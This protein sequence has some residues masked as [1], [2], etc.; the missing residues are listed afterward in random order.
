MVRVR[1]YT[2]RTCSYCFAAKQLLDEK[3]IA[4][5]EIDVTG[6]SEARE[7]LREVTGRR[8]V[9]QIFIDDRSY[10][11][12]TDVARLDRRG[13]LDRILSLPSA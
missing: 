11:G 6:N 13:E 12:F 4:Y 1:I 3:G 8:T 7:W 10:G 2:T 9:P 5:D